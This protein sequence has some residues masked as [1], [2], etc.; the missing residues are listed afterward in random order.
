MNLHPVFP[1]DNRRH[2]F[3]LA[4]I[5]IVIAISAA[6]L[7]FTLPVGFRFYRRQLVD[8]TSRS[9]IETLRR[10]HTYSVAGRND[11]KFGLKVIAASNT[12]VLFQGDSFASRVT[13]EDEIISYPS[14]VNIV[15]TSTEIIFSK[16]FGTSTVDGMWSVSNG[17]D[18]IN[19]RI[20]PQGI[21]EQ[22]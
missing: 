11:S 7:A 17:S 2:G 9:L 1:R 10:A 14:T 15:A 19:I 4:E 22:Q 6:V 8:D 18:S 3:T 5:L 21:I 13:S 16:V 20:Y 12:F